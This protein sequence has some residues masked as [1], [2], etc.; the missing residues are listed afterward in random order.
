MNAELRAA[1]ICLLDVRHH[2][3][4]IEHVL[5]YPRM[6]SANFPIVEEAFKLSSSMRVNVAPSKSTVGSHAALIAY[7]RSGSLG[8][9]ISST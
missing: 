1:D 9:N 2:V 5:P 8:G 7:K 4:V 6:K 3:R